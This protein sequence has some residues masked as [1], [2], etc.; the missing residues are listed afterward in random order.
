M[1]TAEYIIYRFEMR[2]RGRREDGTGDKRCMGCS[3]SVSY[4]PRDEE[5]GQNLRRWEKEEMERRKIIIIV[6]VC[7]NYL[8]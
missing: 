7:T 2:G 1:V 4:E 3:R 5:G 8:P 6:I